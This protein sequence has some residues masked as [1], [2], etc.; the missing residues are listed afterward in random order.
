MAEKLIKT[1]IQRETS[2]LYYIKDAEIW[3][4]P[5]KRSGLPA[6]TKAQRVMSLELI[7]EP[8]FMYFLDKDGDVA[9]APRQRGGP[10]GPRRKR[11]KAAAKTSAALRT[12]KAEKGKKQTSAKK[13]SA[14]GRG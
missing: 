3:R 14:R 2:F 10:K 4:S 1:A 13:A 6:G 9:R 11:S 5:M 8:G 12:R 7:K